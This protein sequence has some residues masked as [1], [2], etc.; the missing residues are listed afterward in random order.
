[1]RLFVREDSGGRSVSVLVA[2]PPDTLTGAPKADPSSEN[3]TVPVR[4]PEPGATALTVAVK[5]TDWPK[6]EGLAEEA[7]V[8]LLPAWLTLWVTVA[9]VLAVKLVSAL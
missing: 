7:T 1:M 8:V 9:E 4:V 3:C 5:V 2:L 6:T